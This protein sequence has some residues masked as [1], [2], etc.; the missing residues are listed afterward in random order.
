MKERLIELQ[1]ETAKDLG[2]LGVG[3]QWQ[4][5]AGDVRKNTGRLR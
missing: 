4:L 3:T 5:A 1:G 2:L